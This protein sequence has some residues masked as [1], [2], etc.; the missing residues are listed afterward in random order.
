[1]VF[2]EA[3]PGHD[4]PVWRENGDINDGIV[5][6]PHWYDL[7]AIFS[8]VALDISSYLEDRLKIFLVI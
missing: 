6:A 3:I 5:Y 8:K 4:P 1:M 2:F 7:K